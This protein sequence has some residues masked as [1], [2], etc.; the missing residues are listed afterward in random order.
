MATK[1]VPVTDL[2]RTASQLLEE[3]R[4][5]GGPV[6]ITHR[7]RPQGVL[8]G[9]DSFEALM[10]RLRDLEALLALREGE[11]PTE[12]TRPTR[13][14]GSARDFVRRLLAHNRSL[15]EELARR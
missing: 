14:S 13:F 5:T 4:E 12:A 1:I 3:L 6:Y 2:R 9:Y 15:F 11:A 10:A 8:I 7:S